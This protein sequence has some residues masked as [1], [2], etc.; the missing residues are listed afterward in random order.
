MSDLIRGYVPILL[1]SVSMLL[2]VLARRKAVHKGRVAIYAVVLSPLAF[3]YPGWMLILL[4]LIPLVFTRGRCREDERG[5]NL[6]DLR[7]LP[8]T[9]VMDDNDS[10]ASYATNG[11]GPKAMRSVF[12]NRVCLRARSWLRGCTRWKQVW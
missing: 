1:G 7:R 6:I 9:L 8:G 11:L 12:Q 2:C 10:A 4:V 3:S 5:C